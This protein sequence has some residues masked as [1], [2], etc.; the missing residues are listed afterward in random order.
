MIISIIE[1]YLQKRSFRDNFICSEKNNANFADSRKTA[2][3]E[4]W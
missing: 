2:K 4:E 3:F 1:S